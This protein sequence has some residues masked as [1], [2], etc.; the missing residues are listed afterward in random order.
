MQI[1]H[2]P[3]NPDFHSRTRSAAMKHS[4]PGTP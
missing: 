1:L 2:K 4:T 3:D